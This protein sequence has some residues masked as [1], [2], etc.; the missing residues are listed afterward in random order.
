MLSNQHQ[1]V[2]QNLFTDLTETHY[3]T[4]CLPG[5]DLEAHTRRKHRGKGLLSLIQVSQI[6]RPRFDYVFPEK[7]GGGHGGARVHCKLVL[8]Y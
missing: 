7:Q 5:R 3:L 4:L 8:P 2:L 6:Y 1:K